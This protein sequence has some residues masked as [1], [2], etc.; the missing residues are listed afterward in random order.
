MNTKIN[1]TEQQKANEAYADF[2]SFL[3]G[4]NRARREREAEDSPL[5]KTAKENLAEL[6]DCSVDE[7]DFE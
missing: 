4:W 1:K 5:E 3:P 7:L 2:V 6:F